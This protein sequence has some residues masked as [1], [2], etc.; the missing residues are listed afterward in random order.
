MV[1]GEH[2]RPGADRHNFGGAQASQEE[3]AVCRSVACRYAKGDLCCGN[4]HP[5]AA[6]TRGPWGRG[7]G[8]LQGESSPDKRSG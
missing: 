8:G 5:L 3:V 7:P 1:R 4:G 6:R 2:V